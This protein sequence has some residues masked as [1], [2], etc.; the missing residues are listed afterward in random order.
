MIVPLKRVI[1]GEYVRKWCLLPY[2]GHPHGYPMYGKRTG[3]PPIA[4]M[5]DELVEPPFYLV[6]REFDL[7]AQEKQMRAR[8]PEWSRKQCRNPRY[9]QQGL[10]RDLIREAEEFAAWNLPK[11]MILVRPEAH[12][13]NL[14]ST[15]RIHGITI[16]KDPQRVVKKMVLIGKRIADYGSARLRNLFR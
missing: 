2:P 3:C 11:S 14:F 4:P 12:G 5:L 7:E 13:V 1:Y 6:I 16:E 15:C 9:W 8:H 10:M